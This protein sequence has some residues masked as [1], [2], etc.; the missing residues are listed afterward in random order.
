MNRPVTSQQSTEHPADTALRLEPM[1]PQ[2]T[3]IQPGSGVIV[4]LELAWGHVRRWWLKTFRPEYV[5]RMHACR[6]GEHNA[7]PHEVLDPRDV[8]Y[9]RNQ[10]GYWWNAADDPFTWRDRLGFARAGLCELLVFSALFFGGAAKLALL[11]FIQQVGN[12]WAVMGW[13]LVAALVVIGGLIVWFFRNPSRRIPAEVGVIVSPADGKV[14]TV[15]HIPHDDFIGGPAVLIGIFLS[16]FNV[17]INRAPCA[18]RVI[19]LTYRKGKFLNALKPESARENEQLEIRLQSTRQ[20]ALKFRVRQ[21]S[22]A[23]ARRI[24]CWLKPGDVLS[25]GEQFGMI[26]LGS[27]TEL[28]LP[29]VKGLELR[30]SVGDKVQAGSSVLACVCSTDRA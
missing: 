12:A 24:V 2:I 16:I 5:A 29:D 19:G 23:I 9:F 26:K 22:G 8:K 11:L 3:S 27:R 17:H 21:I 20:P 15:Q 30:V 7:C 25:A 28:I 13:L 18:T 1:D 4:R 14:V 6:R 10:D